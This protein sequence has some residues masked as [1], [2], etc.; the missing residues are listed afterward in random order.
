MR[1]I[2]NDFS[3]HPLLPPT[4]NAPGQ[5]ASAGII[6]LEA[7]ARECSELCIIIRHIPVWLQG[8][9]TFPPPLAAAVLMPFL[10]L[11]WPDNLTGA[12]GSRER[13]AALPRPRGPAPTML[14]AECQGC[15]ICKG[16]WHRGSVS[17]RAD[18]RGHSDRLSWGSN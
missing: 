9:V 14:A 3:N 8:Q 15:L 16:L 4:H 1:Y 18:C 17:G 2:R 5:K 6:L 13:G 12:S 11:S 7:M 10:F